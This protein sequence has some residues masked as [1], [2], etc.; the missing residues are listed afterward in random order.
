MQ[1]R[2][3]LR[4]NTGELRQMQSK[5][6]WVKI[7][8]RAAG[9]MLAGA[10]VIGAVLYCDSSEPEA[11]PESMVQ[12]VIETPSPAPVERIPEQP[13][14]EVP[15]EPAP[16]AWMIVLVNCWNP[17]PED[18]AVELAPVDEMYKMDARVV[19]P[20]QRMLEDCRAAG[21]EPMICSAYRTHE[22]QVNLFERQVRKQK[23]FGLQGEEAIAAAA[24]VV[25]KP[26]TSE[27]QTGL[28]V[29]LCSENYQILDERQENTPEFQ[30]LRAHCAE[31]GFILRYPPGSTEI[32]GI[33]Y[34]PWHFRY[35]GEI[36]AREIMDA[37]I[38][39]EEYLELKDRL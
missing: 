15:A 22:Y 1:F 12:E 25:A 32:T 28:A 26:D 31:Y 20:L 38:T 7:G 35:V 11:V 24:E 3:I 30:W 17:L 6:E 4:A 34:E 29:D 9:M 19:E 27:H 10:M 23:R 18:F 33:I 37:G 2:A 21:L 5:N 13:E 14:P 16:E 8:L 39:F 36:A